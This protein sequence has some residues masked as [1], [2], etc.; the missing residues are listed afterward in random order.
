M[1]KP[2]SRLT[3]AVYKY[4][5]EGDSPI[6]QALAVGLG[7]FIGA[8]PFIGFHMALA[9]GLGRLFRLNRLRVY[10]AANISNPIAAPFLYALE[11]QVGTKLR[12]GHLLS[13]ATIGDVQ[14]HGIAIDILLGSVVVGLAL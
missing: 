10:V 7:L 12:T 8:S 3:A 13:R 2:L 5:T 4:R 9:L 6:R 11:L 14:W 1:K